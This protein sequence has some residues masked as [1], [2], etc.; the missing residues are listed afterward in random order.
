MSSRSGSNPTTAANRQALLTGSVIVAALGMA[1]IPIP[2]H[3]ALL[4][5]LVAATGLGL[6]AA[7][8]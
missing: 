5:V 8:R 7:S 1:L 6:G 3:L 4:V 2:M